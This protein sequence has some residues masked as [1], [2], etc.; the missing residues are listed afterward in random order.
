MALIHERLSGQERIGGIDMKL[1]LQD[2]TNFLISSYEVAQNRIQFQIECNDLFL[3]IEQ[4]IPCGLI[5]NEVIT[6]SLKHAFPNHAEGKVSIE[7]SRNGKTCQL[8]IADNGVGMKSNVGDEESGSLGLRLVRLLIDQ[9]RG[10]LDFDG[11]RGTSFLIR[12]ESTVEKI[13]V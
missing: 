2:I 8:K 5:A 9:L 13:P 4:A 11:N 6:N 7:F 1:Y 12:F 3:G 10:T